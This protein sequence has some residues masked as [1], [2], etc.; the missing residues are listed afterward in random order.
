MDTS[1]ICSQ[2]CQGFE[3]NYGGCCTVGSRNYIIGPI[4]DSYQFIEH[5]KHFYNNRNIKFEDVLYSYE[6]G[7]RLF[8]D[9]N[10]Y[11][12]SGSYPAIKLDRTKESLPCIFYS[13]EIRSCTIYDVRPL[14]CRQYVCSY[15]KELELIHKE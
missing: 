6:E 1:S 2:K 13:E 4:V 14:S 9:K 15:L 12:D 8:P 5:L 10:T 11:Q 3:G 7:S